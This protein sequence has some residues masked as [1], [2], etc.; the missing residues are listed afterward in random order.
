MKNSTALRRL[1]WVTIIQCALL[2]RTVLADWSAEQLQLIRLS[3][4][5]I[6][7]EV[8]HDQAALER[9]LDDRFLATFA[10]S[11]KTIDRSAYVAWIMETE[12]EP[13]RVIN[14]T[15]N[16]HGETALVIATTTDRK[17]KFTWVAVRKGGQWV[18]IAETF[19]RIAE[20]Q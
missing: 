12:L 2:P 7:A 16:I 14:E 8:G 9:I 20:A 18:V 17:T 11:G 5:W 19:S 6:D 10:S 4:K 3:D 1:L 13:F 15:V